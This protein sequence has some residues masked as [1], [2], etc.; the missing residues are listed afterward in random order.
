M[1]IAHKQSSKL[2]DYWRGSHGSAGPVALNWCSP[3]PPQSTIEWSATTKLFKLSCGKSATELEIKSGAVKIR[4]G[5]GAETS[6]G[7]RAGTFPP[8]SSGEMWFPEVG[9]HS[10][11]NCTITATFV[12]AERGK[13]YVP[14]F[15]GSSKFRLF[16]PN[17]TH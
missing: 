17:T 14:S 3:L 15:A 8:T 2:I 4:L 11:G 12:L 16:P 7:F 1:P 5:N 9:I 13:D 10:D 6:V